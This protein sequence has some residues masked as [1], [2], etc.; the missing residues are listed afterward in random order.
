[1]SLGIEDSNI[2][3][4]KA[5]TKRKDKL[6]EELNKLEAQQGGLI[7]S[8]SVSVIGGQQALH[9]E[10]IK[11]IKTRISELKREIGGIDNELLVRT[12]VEKI[13][14]LD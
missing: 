13:K 11:N 3:D 1:M 5:L 7:D 8:Q 9:R 12:E 14:K 6:S 2:N 10:N 4:F